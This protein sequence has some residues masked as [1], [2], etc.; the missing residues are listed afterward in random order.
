MTKRDAPATHRNRE[1]ILERLGQWLNRP[2]TVLEVASGT[3]QHAVFFAEGLPHVEWRPT[4]EDPSN[5]K[6]ISAW[7]REA[8]LPNLRAPAISFIA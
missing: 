5:L 3:G 1:P 6:S 8:G 7:S 4:D 2:A